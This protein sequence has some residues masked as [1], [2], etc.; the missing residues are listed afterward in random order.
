MRP[1]TADEIDVGFGQFAAF[2]GRVVE[3]A[4]KL[5]VVERN[6]LFFGETL[7]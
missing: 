5:D 6:A 1:A 3:G 2:L 7:Q 4:V